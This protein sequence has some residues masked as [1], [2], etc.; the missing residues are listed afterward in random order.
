MSKAISGFIFMFIIFTMFNAI[1]DGGGGINTTRLSSAITATDTTIPVN[2]T[3][4]FLSVDYLVIGGEKIT[5]TGKT[6]TTFTGCIR[7][8]GKVHANN[9]YVYSPQ[10]S[11][12]NDALGFNIGAVSTSAGYFAVIQIPFKFFTT[13]IPNIITVGMPG[14]DGSIAW[15]GYI[16]F[17]LCIGMV[18]AIAISLIWVA[19]GLLTRVIP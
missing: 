17:A 6:A 18:I 15:I 8:D 7:S 2:S 9:S 12:M 14:V 11:L 19:N 10:T 5:Y 3:S 4:G 16:W 13:T 1:L